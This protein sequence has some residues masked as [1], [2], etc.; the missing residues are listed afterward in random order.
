MVILILGM[1]FTFQK[2]WILSFHEGPWESVSVGVW[3]YES[4]PHPH[5]STEKTGYEISK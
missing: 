3:G 5:T 2:L 1:E 4:V